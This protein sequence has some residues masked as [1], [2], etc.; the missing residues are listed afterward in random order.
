M[1]LYYYNLDDRTRQLML[2]EME[3]D[4]ANNQLHISPFLSG[5]GQRDYPNLL[6]ETI[7]G[8]TD[9]SLAEKLRSHR[10]IARALPRRNKQKSGYLLASVPENAA[11]IVAEGE[12]NRFYIRAVARRALEDGLREIRFARELALRVACRD[13]DGQIFESGWHPRR[14]RSGRENR[15]GAR[16]HDHG[17]DAEGARLRDLDDRQMASRTSAAIP[18]DGARRSSAPFRLYWLPPPSCRKA[19]GRRCQ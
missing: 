11:D 6:R 16:T 18:A 12:F 13:H 7:Q 19:S 5:Q 10:R 14:A 15:A 9:E 4:I 8:G 17:R 3:Y 1:A 2:E